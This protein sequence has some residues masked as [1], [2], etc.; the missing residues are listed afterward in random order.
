LL[1]CSTAAGVEI[2]VVEA[3]GSP[4]IAKAKEMASTV[5][6]VGIAIFPPKVTL[7]RALH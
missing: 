4:S 3:T 6:P 7:K 1:N 5:P 2:I